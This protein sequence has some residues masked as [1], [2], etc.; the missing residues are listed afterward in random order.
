MHIICRRLSGLVLLL[1][2]ASAPAGPARAAETCPFISDQQLVGAMP[3]ARW[4]LISNQD[5]R[6][7]IFQGARGDT[8]M[9]TVLRN[10]TADRAKEL[11]ATFVKTL[12]ERMPIAPVSGISRIISVRQ[13]LC[14]AT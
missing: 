7:C 1:A 13:R 6:G 10:P 2:I 12:A 3:A 9:L 11:Y 4:S 8:L 14:Q 5:G